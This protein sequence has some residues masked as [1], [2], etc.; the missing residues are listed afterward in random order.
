MVKCSA[1]RK[2]GDP[3]NREATEADGLCLFHHNARLDIRCAVY[4]VSTG[5][6]CRAFADG[7]DGLCPAH[8]RRTTKARMS[9][10]KST[11]IRAIGPALVVIVEKEAPIRIVSMLNEAEKGGYLSWLESKPELWNAVLAF[12]QRVK[13]Q[14]GS[15]DEWDAIVDGASE[16]P[17][18]QP[19][20]T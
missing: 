5:K 8:R 15:T 4:A 14:G 9:E 19:A 11:T 10:R 3:C 13:A 2:N 6:P 12:A 16:S 18:P 17:L 7:E 20:T 1:T